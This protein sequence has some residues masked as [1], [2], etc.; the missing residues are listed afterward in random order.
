MAGIMDAIDGQTN[1]VGQNRLELLLFT[2]EGD[3]L[4]GINVFKVREVLQ[5]PTLVEL[6]RR[7]PSVRGISHI[8]GAT[9]PI[10]DLNH[11]IGRNPLDN[12][13][14][15]SFVIIAEYNR[16]IQGFLVRTVEKIV[17]LT[18]N[19]IHPPPIGSG[20]NNYL[21]AVTEVD[22]KIVE[23]ID[24][25]KVLSEIVCI[26]YDEG[27]NDRVIS[28]AEGV[29][30]IE[31]LV[32]DDSSVARKQI[33]RCLTALGLKVTLMNDGLEAFTHLQDLTDKNIDVCKKYVVMISD[34][35]MP[36]MDG[37]TLTAKVRQSPEMKDMQIVLHTSLSGIF[38]EAMV[39]K[40]GAN[41]FLSKFRPDELAQ[42]V[43]KHVLAKLGVQLLK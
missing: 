9:I 6:P 13:T 19:T 42:L 21:T 41:N 3:Q 27:F 32:V 36:E 33:D 16:L 18:W 11:A 17:N 8:R 34:V 30:P 22:K 39:A 15:G 43:A 29:A 24:V 31:V 7:H 37:Y 10:L 26:T 40:V 23:I 4:Y 20:K 25:E 12:S 28:L 38:N 2:L 14:E 5:C 35:E 1:L